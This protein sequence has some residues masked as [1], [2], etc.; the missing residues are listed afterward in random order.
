MQQRK[1]SLQAFLSFI[2]KSMKQEHFKSMYWEFNMYP[3][4]TQNSKVKK[5]AF[6][7]ALLIKLVDVLHDYPKNI[8]KY[9][10][11]IYAHSEYTAYKNTFMILIMMYGGCRAS[12]ALSIKYSDIIETQSSDAT[13]LYEITV[14]GKGLKERPVYIKQVHLK[15]HLEYLLANRGAN[16]FIS[17][18]KNSDTPLSRQPLFSF[19]KKIFNLA[20][21][22]KKGLHIFRHH[23][24]SSFVEQNGNIKIL[25]ELLDHSNITTTM[26]YSDISNEAKKDALGKM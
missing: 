10:V 8:N 14:I 20:G 18:K 11:K 15:E 26:I 17:G 13:P 2:D 22:D 6:E 23:F 21:S 1:A 12:E 7:E 3:L 9:L 4:P 25:Q 16:D 19:T 5:L 24:A